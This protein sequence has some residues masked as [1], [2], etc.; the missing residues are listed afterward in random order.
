MTRRQVVS[1]WRGSRSF[2]TLVGMRLVFFSVLLPP[3]APTSGERTR[4][5]GEGG[6]A[7]SGHVGGGSQGSAQVRFTKWR[8]NR[9]AIQKGNFI[10]PG[11][12]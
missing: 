7:G 1:V 9:G 10:V 5:A 8:S 12:R 2:I 11:A 3:S 6:G 4:C